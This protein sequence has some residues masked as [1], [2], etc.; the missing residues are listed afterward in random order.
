[1]TFPC[2]RVQRDFANVE[3]IIRMCRSRIR[4]PEQWYGDYLAASARPASPS[5][6]SRSCARTTALDVVRDVIRE[7]FDYSERRM[8][9][10]IKQ[11]ARAARCTAARRTTRTRACPT[12]SR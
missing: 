1:M 10:A 9:Q 3:D 5:G 12:A 2:V 8:E 7:W 6:G 11:A 4:V